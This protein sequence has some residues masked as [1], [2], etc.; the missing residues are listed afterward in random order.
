MLID[1]I[2]HFVVGV[3]EE[4]HEERVDKT[5]ENDLHEVLRIMLYFL[6]C[7]KTCVAIFASLITL[8]PS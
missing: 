6:S 8:P 2:S 4:E 1:S 3:G 7:L 5:L